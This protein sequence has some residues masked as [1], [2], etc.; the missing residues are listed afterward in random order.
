[1]SNNLN[2]PSVRSATR[3]ALQRIESLE[4]DLQNLVSGVQ[5]AFNNMQSQLRGMAEIVDVFIRELG[6][7]VVEA[8][9]K[10]IGRAHV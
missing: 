8:Q 6:Q 9:V 2:K 3:N 4:G 7:E 5:N 10:E 1:M